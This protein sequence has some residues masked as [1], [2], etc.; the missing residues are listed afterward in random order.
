MLLKKLLAT[1]GLIVAY[2]NFKTFP[3]RHLLYRY[4][5]AFIL[6]TFVI[7]EFGLG[8][9]WF[10]KHHFNLWVGVILG[11]WLAST[12]FDIFIW[13]SNIQHWL[14]PEPEI[15][16]IEWYSISVTVFSAILCGIF[17]II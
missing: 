5:Q 12:A 3:K 13:N 9:F 6:S 7:I 15:S 14:I 4:I 2:I 10:G 16:K 17:F 11:F 1:L 8:T